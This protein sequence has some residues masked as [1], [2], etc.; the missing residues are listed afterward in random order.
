MIT[1]IIGIVLI[2][3]GLLIKYGKMYFLIAGLNT[4]NHKQIAEYNLERIGNLYRNV[5]CI[6]GIFMIIGNLLSK[7]FENYLFD[8]FFTLVPVIIGC[9]I[10]LSKSNSDKYKSWYK[11]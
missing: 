8:L 6:I 2:I 3:A 1:F 11:E 7:H 10:L 5:L 9:I 4:M